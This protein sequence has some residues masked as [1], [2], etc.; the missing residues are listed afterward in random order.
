MEERDRHTDKN[1]EREGERE[2]GRDGEILLR[3]V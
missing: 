1:N 3:K 2:I